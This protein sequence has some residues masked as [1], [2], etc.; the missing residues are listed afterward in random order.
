MMTMR[1]LSYTLFFSILFSVPSLLSQHNDMF[2]RQ[3]QEQG[4]QCI[5]ENGTLLFALPPGH[6]PTVRKT[7]EPFK[8]SNFYFVDFT[9][10]ILPVKDDDRYYLI[11]RK[12]EE[13]RD[14][15][16]NI[17]W[18]SALEEGIFRVFERFENRRNASLIIY[19]DKDG[20]PVFNGQKFWEASR[21]RD[22]RA[23]VQ[24]DDGNG[25]WQLIDNSGQVIL[26]LSDTIP[27]D[28]RRIAKFERGSWQLSVKS[29]KNSY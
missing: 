2:V 25:A 10:N 6:E 12:G 5:D 15:G 7:K 18:I 27:G 24:L 8:L 3:S 28:I 23:V 29:E 26:N 14:M 1:L 19:H 20:N 11:N 13:V 9:E 17:N 4:F 22:G 21:F 16:G